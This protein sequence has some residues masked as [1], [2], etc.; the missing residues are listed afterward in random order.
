[1]HQKTAT[2]TLESIPMPGHIT[3]NLHRN[4]ARTTQVPS[5]FYV[6][7][8]AANEWNWQTQK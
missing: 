1:M 4:I 7:V 3:T 8:A 2:T 5:P 6:I